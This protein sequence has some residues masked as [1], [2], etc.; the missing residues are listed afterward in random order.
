M[1]F[2]FCLSFEEIINNIAGLQARLNHHIY[3]DLDEVTESS[4]CFSTKAKISHRC[5]VGEAL[6]DG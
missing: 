4:K 6:V 5:L 3:D 2:F 1:F